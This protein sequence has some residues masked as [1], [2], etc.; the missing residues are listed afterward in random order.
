MVR[1][2]W[3]LYLEFNPRLQ[4][5]WS[6]IDGPA[7]AASPEIPDKDMAPDSDSDDSASNASSRHSTD[8]SEEE[9]DACASK[10][11]F[12][13]LEHFT[14]RWTLTLLY[15]GCQ[16]IRCPILASDLLHL[17]TLNKLP[18][19]SPFSLVPHEFQIVQGMQLKLTAKVPSFRLFHRS[20]RLMAQ[21]L[22]VR[23]GVV[24]PAPAFPTVACRLLE[25]FRLPGTLP[26]FCC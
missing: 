11:P 7:V 16:H 26:P 25:H 1:K 4:V 9:N 6:K 3:G 24:V 15:L 13:R 17:A 20:T 14:L 18:Y 8:G 23:F 12:H 2:F 10:S 19:L 21:M 5:D 22:A